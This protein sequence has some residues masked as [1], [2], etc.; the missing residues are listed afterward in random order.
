MEEEEEASCVW[1][2]TRKV[3]PRS[4][5]DHS[6]S[7]RQVHRFAA[8]LLVFHDKYRNSFSWG[9]AV[10]YHEA[11][12]Q[13][14][15]WDAH[16]YKAQQ[17]FNIHESGDHQLTIKSMCR[18]TAHLNSHVHSFTFGGRYSALFLRTSLTDFFYASSLICSLVNFTSELKLVR[19]QSKMTK[20]PGIH[21]L[22][23]E[24]NTH[25]HLTLLNLQ[26]FLVNSLSLHACMM[27]IIIIFF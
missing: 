14:D 25:I 19:P 3:A 18:V 23:K 8:H 13:E 17:T 9:G 26:L 4:E 16:E 22:I 5:A 11:S 20:L 27:T 15:V 6:L 24:M 12:R 2:E 1:F 7:E 21:E 10:L